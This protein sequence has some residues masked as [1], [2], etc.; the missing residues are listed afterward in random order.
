MRGMNLTQEEVDALT[1]VGFRI[2]ARP[3]VID[4]ESLPPPRGPRS[5]TGT[6]HC[7]YVPMAIAAVELRGS[8]AENRDQRAEALHG[9][10]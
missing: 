1:S 5:P 3:N 9:K 7:N 8:G 10:S 2:V 6:T 4:K